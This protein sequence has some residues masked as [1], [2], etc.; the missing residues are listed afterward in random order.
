MCELKDTLSLHQDEQ[1]A[2][3]CHFLHSSHQQ[4]L[5]KIVF[6]DMQSLLHNVFI[7]KKKKTARRISKYDPVTTRIFISTSLFIIS[8]HKDLTTI[9]VEGGVKNA[10]SPSNCFFNTIKPKHG[11][12]KNKKNTVELISMLADESVFFG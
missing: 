8:T 7:Q 10:A 12:L 5:I 6:L 3:G 4:T 11:A 2:G 9:W 1:V